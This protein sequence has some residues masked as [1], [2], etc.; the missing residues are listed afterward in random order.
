MSKLLTETMDCIIGM[1]SPMQFSTEAA[2]TDRTLA[3]AVLTRTMSLHI[4]GAVPQ[5]CLEVCGCD[6]QEAR[7]A[8]WQ[9][10]CHTSA[11]SQDVAH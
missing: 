1:L 11:C 8:T 2:D 6:V 3:E 5:K 9:V 4:S 10:H 7:R